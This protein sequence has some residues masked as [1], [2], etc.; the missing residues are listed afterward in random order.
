M[1]SQCK[2][3]II[4][5][6]MDNIFIDGFDIDILLYENKTNNVIANFNALLGY[7]YSFLKNGQ[8]K[9]RISNEY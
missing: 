3:G 7:M 8:C 5:G 9:K 6:I 1:A 4:S 2:R